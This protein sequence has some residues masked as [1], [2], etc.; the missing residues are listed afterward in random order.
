VIIAAPR[1]GS[2]KTVLTLGL[3]R[4]LRRGG[5]AVASGK[6]GPDYI[7]PAFHAA[8]TGRPCLS[9]DS[10]AMRAESLGRLITGIGEAMGTHL[11]VIEGVMGLFDGAP[12]RAPLADGSTASLAALTGWPV[13]LVLDVTGQAASAAAVARGFVSHNPDVTVAAVVLNRVAGPRHEDTLR[14]AFADSLPDLPV[15]GAVPRDQRLDLPHRHLGLIQASEHATLDSFLNAA[16]DLVESHVDMATLR[17]LARGSHS[18][19]QAQSPLLPPL[20]QRIAVAQDTAYAFA[21]PAQLSAWQAAG[22]EVI[23]FSPL[24]NQAPDAGADAVFLPGGYPELHA[25]VLAAASTFLGGLRDA[26]QG[27]A[28]VYGECGGFMTLGETLIDAQGTR[29]TMAGLLPL[30]TSFAERRLHLGYRRGI[31]CDDGPFGPAGTVIRG[32]EF[33]YATVVP[34]PTP[35]TCRPLFQAD[36]AAS[37][38]LGA[39]GLLRQGDGVR[40]A[41]SFLHAIDCEAPA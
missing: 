8:A 7:D 39:M 24:A 26:A 6:V 11:A 28:W 31:Q 16:A 20:G 37:T 21:Y 40:I 23:P 14:R 10:W 36:D 4:A 35:Q 19:P 2:G 15:I 34:S 18:L 9:L 25:G 38:P 12:V 29:H 32:H 41:G 22:A 27:G 13:V 5:L 17:R 33:H 3:L 1:S 30:T